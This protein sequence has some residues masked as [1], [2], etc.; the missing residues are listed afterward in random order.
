MHSQKEAGATAVING[1]NVPEGSEHFT[2]F[3]AQADMKH[4]CAAQHT[5]FAAAA[6]TAPV[7]VQFHGFSV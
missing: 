6:S 7:D 2:L 1:S 3:C 5:V 4:D